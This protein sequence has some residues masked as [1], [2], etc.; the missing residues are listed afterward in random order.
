MLILVLLGISL[1]IFFLS[2]V[3]PTDVAR[4]MAGP[5]ADTEGVE[6]I[7][8]LYGLDLP[9]WQQ[10]IRFMGGLLRGDLGTSYKTLRPV[11][12]DIAEFLSATIELGVYALLFS[13]I[14]GFILGTLSAIWENSPVDQFGRFLAIL[15]LSIPTFWLAMV[16]Q[17]T[18][19]LR[20]DLLPFGGRLSD[21]IIPPPVITGFLTID[22]LLAGRADAFK[23]AIFHLIMPAVILGFEPLA[24]IT[25]VTRNSLIEVM[26]ELYIVTARAKGLPERLVVWRH[27]IRNALIPIVTITGLQIGHMMGGAILVETVLVWP[28]IGRYYSRAI[29]SADYNPVIGVTL[30]IAFMRISI[31]YVVD[32]IY[33]K[34][35][36][37]IRY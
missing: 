18:L 9:L 23:D 33:A 24:V 1:L 14:C 36:P 16:G 6:T 35:D 28:G 10:Y 32:L 8:K 27:A 3:A 29:T 22:S 20:F 12:K 26:R 11:T 37:R 34:L 13:F 2:R 5:F 25:R 30:V 7:R 15:G 31:N 19:Y 17:L 21:F 4:L